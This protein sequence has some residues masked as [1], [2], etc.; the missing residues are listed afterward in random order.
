MAHPDSTERAPTDAIPQW[1]QEWPTLDVEGF[2]TIPWQGDSLLVTVRGEWRGALPASEN[3]PVLVLDDGR[4]T[5]RFAAVPEPAEAAGPPPR[6]RAV[7]S[8]P[9]KLRAAVAAPITLD[10]GPVSLPLI[11]GRWRRTAAQAADAG[12]VI[13]PLVL[14]ERRARRAELSETAQVESTAQAERASDALRDQ[15]SEVDSR[16]RAARDRSRGLEAELAARTRALREATQS[17]H[18][19]RNLR[20]ELV[21]EERARRQAAED[22]ATTLRERFRQAEARAR[23]RARRRRAAPRRARDPADGGRGDRGSPPGGAR[24]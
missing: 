7:F 24:A 1:P 11:A 3:V 6:F 14:A 21:T 8:I 2:T 9:Q 5:H 13:D 22:E 23:A 15:L 18:A 12:T 16:L 4:R 10:L 20:E 17:A 19:E